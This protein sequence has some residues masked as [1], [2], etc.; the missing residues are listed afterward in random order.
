M[1]SSDS[2]K[3]KGL[4]ELQDYI[5]YWGYHG[6]AEIEPLSPA[7]ITSP[8]IAHSSGSFPS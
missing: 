5:G 4:R 8:R 6:A 3:L 7:C 2:D 1:T